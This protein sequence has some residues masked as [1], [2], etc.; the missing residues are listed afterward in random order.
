MNR[1]K[2]IK[3]AV[4]LF[5]AA[6]LLLFG[7][8]SASDTKVSDA[9]ATGEAAEGEIKIGNFENGVSCHDPQII[10]S[11]GNYY[12]TGSH[13]VLA[14]STDLNHWD[15]ISNGNAK[16]YISNLYEGSLPAFSYVGKNEQGGYSVWAGNIY[17][18]EI[19]DK[20]MLY[21][22]TSSTYI[23][24]ALA[25]AVSDEPEGPYEYV[26]D[27]LYSGFTA[28][29][30]Q[31]TDLFDVLGQDAEVDR[32]FKYGGYN[33]ELWPNCIDPAVFTDEDGT[34]WMVYGSWSGGIFLL[35][36]D[37]QTGL[38]IH[39]KGDEA[40]NVDSYFGYHLIGGAH[41]ACEG[42]YI[43]YNAQNGYYYL[44]VSYGNLQREGGYQIR[45]FRSK[46][47][48]GPYVDEMGNT[49][50]D[51]ED[52]F[53]YGLKM[54]GNYIFPSLKTAYMA[55]GG[56]SVFTGKDGDI[57]I[58]YHQRFDAGTEYHEPRVH[59]LFLTAD[60]WYVMAPFERSDEQFMEG[61]LSAETLEG[62]FYVLNHGTDV[63]S[64]IHRGEKFKFHDGKITGEMEG[65]YEF[66]EGKNDITVTFEGQTFTGVAFRMTDEA[67]NQTLCL[68]AAG[69]K[70][71]TIWCV[72]YLK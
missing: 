33:N 39:P 64:V 56:Q 24:S 40:D 48:T 34:M 22:C 28:S 31:E 14:E 12:M 6:S 50:Q 51:E 7:C 27:L 19:M 1:N 70:N 2:M 65:S 68:S 52:Y 54:A 58:T 57:Y 26:G 67:G 41:H 10:E 63:S 38:V 32:Y 59:R 66:E 21:F 69:D 61:G 71:E 36:I 15:Y 13:M 30:V 4:L 25:L 35:E 17:Y 44:F 23:K 8:Q 42:P 9:N 29:E 37:P 45:Q 72:K 43:T 16:K 20:Y 47:V 62:T 18:N 5:L 55:P 53:S 46:T 60:D 11:E 3:K 49:L